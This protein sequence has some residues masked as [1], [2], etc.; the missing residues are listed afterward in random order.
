VAAITGWQPATRRPPSPDARA[1]GTGAGI[2]V[3]ITCYGGNDGP[4]TVVPAADPAYQAARPTLG[5]HPAEV[6]PL[7]DGLGL[8]PR[9]GGLHARWAAGQL[10]VGR[11]VGRPDPTLSHF[12]SMDVW[13][14]GSPGGLGTGWL[15]RWLDKAGRDPLRVISLGA[16]LPP[17]LRGATAAATAITGDTI[18]LPQ[19]S[20]LLAG[21]SAVW[22]PRW[23][24]S[25]GS[26]PQG[27]QRASTR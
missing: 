24:S 3:L 25:P 5:Y 12:A 22:R 8:N 1:A 4:N 27:R 16:T 26:S 11:G 2:L 13:Q 23:R 18:T 20:A 15:G 6:L 10:A 9:L 21:W 7:A 14:T 19:R 17:E